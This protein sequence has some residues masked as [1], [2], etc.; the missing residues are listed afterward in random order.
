MYNGYFNIL[1]QKAADN[2]K[3]RAKL[4]RELDKISTVME[5]LNKQGAK[6]QQVMD[7][8]GSESKGMK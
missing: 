2:M 5:G 1:F 6:L 8:L 3:A 4:E 7:S